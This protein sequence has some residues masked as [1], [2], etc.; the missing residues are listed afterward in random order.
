MRTTIVLLVVGAL[1][2]PPGARA[3]SYKW[4]DKNGVVHFTDNPFD[5]PEPQRS[6]VLRELEKERQEQ[7]KNNEKNEKKPGPLPP[8]AREERLPPGRDVAPSPKAE[9][10][11]GRKVSG[12]TKT[13]GEQHPESQRDYWR[14]K[15]K[16]A[17]EKVAGLEETC[18]QKEAERDQENRNA[19][20]FAR[21][22]A[23]EAS[24]KAGEELAGCRKQLEKA[25][26]YLRVG[27]LE[28]AREA[29]VPAGWLRD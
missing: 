5:L 23:R 8:G 4:V 13:T 14:N 25:R 18:A 20:V 22:G 3:E 16:T 28:E 6:K 19:L 12:E 9:N 1:L 17:R 7:D 24:Q 29:G 10:G 21:P 15:L 26:R 2:A 27:L 11:E